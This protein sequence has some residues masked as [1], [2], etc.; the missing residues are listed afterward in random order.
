M[1]LGIQ[2]RVALVCAAS[3]GLGRAIALGLASEGCR[4]VMCARN[5][6]SLEAAAEQ[7]R[8]ETGAEVRAVPADVS[9]EDDCRRFVRCALDE[10]GAADILLTNTG[11]PPAGTFDSTDEAAWRAGIENTLMNV[12]RL[13]QLVVPHMRKKKWGRIVNI[14]SSSAK[15]PIGGL[16]LSNVLRPAIVGY[17]KSLAIELAADNILVN[18]VCPGM[19]LTDRLRHLAEIRA[20]D[21]DLTIEEQLAKMAQEVPLGR[22]GR[23]EELAD[24][25]VFLCSE[26]A[27]FVTGQSILVDGGTYRGLA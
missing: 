7:V 5:R 9:R 24:V 21:S 22:L 26:R 1:D 13:T 20:G 8:G 15:Q 12:A 25:V 6:D 19:F 27:S 14:A 3:K 16:L 2:G 11:G 23:P 4:V 17:A 18:N 10:F